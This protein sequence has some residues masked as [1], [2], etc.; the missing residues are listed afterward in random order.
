[1]TRAARIVTAGG[2]AY[3]VGGLSPSLLAGRR[4]GGVDLRR[5]G[6]GTVS[7]T[8]VYR[9]A[10]L[11]PMLAAGLADVAKGAAATSLAR[12][13]TADDAA[14]VPLAVAAV[15]AGHTYS[16]WL[17]GAGGRGI[18]PAIGAFAVEAPL[19]AGLLLAGVG[20]G[21]LAGET[22]VGALV[23]YLALPP[24]LARSRGR[25]GALAGAAVAAVMLAKRLTG[26]AAPRP[27]TLGWRLLLDRDTR[28]PR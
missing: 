19:G 14:G 8:G 18:A 16:P 12:R 25:R 23:A 28:R 2:A 26:N 22:A 1:M 13:L 7:G 11:G 6:T 21:R 20:L 5:T 15:V 24:A 9:T 4:W 3:A 17:R 10:G 27:G